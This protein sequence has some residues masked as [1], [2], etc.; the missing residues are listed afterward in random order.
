MGADISF[1]G[2]DALAVEGRPGAL[3]RAI[4]NLMDNALAHGTRARARLV[5]S[6]GRVDFAVEDDGPGLPEDQLEKVFAPFYRVES[7]RS[8]DTGGVGLGLAVARDVARAP[9]G[10]VVLANVPGGGLRAT[11]SLP[12]A[13]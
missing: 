8:R 4:A 3:R 9:G 10:D 1:D 5:A 12:A 2:P 7:S 6:E 13:A 11:L